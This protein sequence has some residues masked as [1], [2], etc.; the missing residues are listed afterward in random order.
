MLMN[1]DHTVLGLKPRDRIAIRFPKDS[2][3]ETRT[4]ELQVVCVDCR[5]VTLG[6]DEGPAVADLSIAR[7]DPGARKETEATT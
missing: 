1:I 5:G 3:G 6:V 4:L 2:C 7:N